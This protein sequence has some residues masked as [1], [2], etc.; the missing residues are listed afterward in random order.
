M[1]KKR[2]DQ[3][4]ID[5]VTTIHRLGSPEAYAQ[6][7]ICKASELNLQSCMPGNEDVR[8]QGRRKLRVLTEPFVPEYWGPCIDCFCQLHMADRWG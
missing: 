6:Q 5:R 2:N 7:R 3:I 4:L 8:L 1:E